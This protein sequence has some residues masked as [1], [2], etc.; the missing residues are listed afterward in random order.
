[1][2]KIAKQDI[3]DDKLNIHQQQRKKRL[4]NGD[5]RP[6]HPQYS[7]SAPA[8]RY[9]LRL[10]RNLNEIPSVTTGR[11]CFTCKS[12]SNTLQLDL[13]YDKHAQFKH[14]CENFEIFVNECKKRRQLQSQFHDCNNTSPAQ[15]QD[16]GNINEGIES[17]T[18]ARNNSDHHRLD[19]SLLNS[20][21]MLKN[22]RDQSTEN[23]KMK[24]IRSCSISPM[25]TVRSLG[26][27]NS[28]REFASRF[29]SNNKP[30]RSIR[31]HNSEPSS[32]FE[33]ESEDTSELAEESPIL[34]N[35]IGDTITTPHDPPFS[36]QTRNKSEYIKPNIFFSHNNA[37]LTRPD[38]FQEYMEERM[39]RWRPGNS[40]FNV[41]DTMEGKHPYQQEHFELEAKAAKIRPS[42][43]FM[44]LKTWF[45][46][47]IVIPDIENQMQS[48]THGKKNEKTSE[49]MQDALEFQLPEISEHL[50]KINFKV[51]SSN[52]IIPKPFKPGECSHITKGLR[53]TGIKQESTPIDGTT[54]T[55]KALPFNDYDLNFETKDYFSSPKIE[56]GS[57]AIIDSMDEDIRNLLNGFDNFLADCFRSFWDVCTS[58]RNICFNPT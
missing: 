31:L 30:P 16:F 35:D 23:T 1:M 44:A 12:H 34:Y 39:A 52:S 53:D 58:L 41:E 20:S 32:F 15:V 47:K 11:G 25:R 37:S 9:P 19:L 36:L 17:C 45:D 8:T 43:P 57:N 29:S 55:P 33:I 28:T 56:Q 4:Q 21:H 38:Y 26:K 18:I 7:Q 22:E 5:L 13:I 6:Q 51:N 10:V 3:H 42:N 40:Q 2:L 14:N 27:A 50:R 54:Y 48:T 24:A 46:G 49:L